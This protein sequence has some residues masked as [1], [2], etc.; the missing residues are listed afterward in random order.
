[1]IQRIKDDNGQGVPLVMMTHDAREK[2]IHGF[3][4]S[5]GVRAG[6]L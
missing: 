6:I 1:V 2:K 4:V 3:S 5:M